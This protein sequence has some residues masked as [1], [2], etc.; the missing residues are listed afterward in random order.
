VK[1]GFS[2]PIAGAWATPANQV[3]VA[4]HA[5]AL[6]F[7]SIWAFQRLLYVLEPKNEYYG[8]PGKAWPRVWEHTLDPIVSFAH[9]AGLTKTIRLGTSVLIM[10]FYQP[11]V[12]AKQLATLDHV[13]GGRLHVGLGLGWSE[14]EYAATGASFE[15]RGARA[16]EF[17]D[18][19]TTCWRD[20]PVEFHGT[21]YAVPRS[22]IEPKPVQKP[23]PPITIGGYAPRVLRRAAMRADGYNGGNVP[24][25][26]MAPLLAELA[27]AARSVGKD[28]AGL[29]IVCRGSYA[30]IDAP[31]GGSGRR[32]LWGT[33]DEIRDDIRRYAA[34]GVT[35]LFLEANFQPGGADVERVLREMDALAPGP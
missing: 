1:L 2:L 29:E 32:P 4:Q 17:L 3:R 18:C 21:F 33:L 12:L 34:L 10:P 14:D 5:E 7:H 11:V 26:R 19:L 25:D 23:R 9:V 20:D 30:V 22:R 28:P 35:E 13:S 8:A 6:G 27:D 15:R 31:Q 24:F 16:D